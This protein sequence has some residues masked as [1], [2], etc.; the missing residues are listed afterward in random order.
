MDLRTNVTPTPPLTEQTP[1]LDKGRGIRA[2]ALRTKSMVTSRPRSF[3]GII[4][5]LFMIGIGAFLAFRRR[6]A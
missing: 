2:L 3:M 5:G 4:G 6:R 1:G